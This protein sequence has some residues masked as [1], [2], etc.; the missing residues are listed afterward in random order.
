MLYIFFKYILVP[1]YSPVPSHKRSLPIVHSIIL[2]TVM[3]RLCSENS[4]FMT[5]VKLFQAKHK[6]PQTIPDK[7]Q[8][9]LTKV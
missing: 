1:N 3:D 9:D 7:T 6:Q 5:L 2:I 4:V 8:I